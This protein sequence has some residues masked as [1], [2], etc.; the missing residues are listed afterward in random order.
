MPDHSELTANLVSKAFEVIGSSSFQVTA[1]LDVE[2]PS[3][4]RAEEN[5]MI[6]YVMQFFAVAAVLIVG[7]VLVAIITDVGFWG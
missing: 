1:S 6:G 2:R 3:A 5:T 7:M 4:A